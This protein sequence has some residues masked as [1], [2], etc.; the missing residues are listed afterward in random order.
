M[1]DPDGR[2]SNI[3]WQWARSSDGSTGWVDIDEATSGIY[4]PV[5]ADADHYLRATANY[6]DRESATVTKTVAAATDE[7][8]VGIPHIN[9]GP[10]FVD[11]DPTD[12]TVNENSAEVALVGNPVEAVDADN[13]V[14]VYTIS[15]D[16]ADAFDVIAATG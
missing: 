7:P 4:T 13:D 14:L 8:V 1:A 9:R 10:E 3:S 11:Q 15:G 2:T 12:R 16:D 5:P 6:E